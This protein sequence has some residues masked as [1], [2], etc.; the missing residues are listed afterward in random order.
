VPRLIRLYPLLFAVLPLL[1]AIDRHPGQTAM[2]DL[3]VALIT[4]LVAGIG[5]FAMTSFLMRG[6]MG[7]DV[8][9]LI[10]M[11]VVVWF[12]GYPRTF[13]W[14][15]ERSGASTTSLALIGGAATAL[16]VGWLIG[17]PRALNTMSRFL[18]VT[19]SLATGWFVLGIAGDRVRAGWVT[20]RS[21]L[22]RDLERPIPVRQ[23][24]LGPGRRAQRDIY[25]IVLDEHANPEVLRRHFGFNGR[26]FEDSL[27]HLGFT[28]P[29]AVRSN[30]AY[31]LLSLPSLLNFSHMTRLVGEVGTGT[32]DPTLLNYLVENN[33]TVAFLKSQGYRFVFAPSQWWLATSHNRHADST[34][35][36][37]RGTSLARALTSTHFR[38]IWTE[39]TALR[40]LRLDF[41]EDAPVIRRTFAQLKLL[42][43]APGP[44][45]VLAHVLSPH[46]PDVFG[47]GCEAN[48]D[49][50]A[51]VRGAKRAYTD[52]VH[53]VDSLVLDLVTSLLRSSSV[54]PIILLQSDH[55]SVTQLEATPP[56]TAR[57]VSRVQAWERF[58]T[59]GAYYVPD[60][61]DRLFSQP[62]TLVNVL[63][64][65]LVHYFGADVPREP[66]TFY[67]SLDGRPLD[68]VPVR[69][70]WLEGP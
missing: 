67:F 48:P 28:I 41:R 32:N 55:G 6:R 26:V 24:E 43:P 64:N 58:N 70:Q 38:R 52:Q 39:I 66:D 68:F 19:G 63:R 50:L 40:L 61:G 7:D 12:F 44:K 57:A 56:A 34:L 18:M 23:S 14:L 4:V 27:R 5:T 21:G 17:H 22:A 1:S 54:P 29:P 33:R 25:L 10:L 36:S 11:T 3:A 30:Y 42:G 15:N 35:Q 13:D 47:P 16:V 31:T 49:V 59:F 60:G 65:L 20:H 53:C 51:R 62:V 46:G 37:W 9:P 2:G 45:F 69:Q 8:P